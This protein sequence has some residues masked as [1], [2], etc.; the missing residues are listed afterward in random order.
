[1]NTHGFTLV[2]SRR[3]SE[4]NGTANMW[5]HDATGAQLLSVVNDDEN[6]CF[7]AAFRTPPADSTGVAHIMEHSVLCGS[8]KYPVK[9]PFVELLKGS[10]QTFLNAFTFPDKTCYPVASAN[11]QDFYN[12]VDVYID[13]VFHPRI[14]EDIFRQEGWHVEAE[15]PDGPWAYKGVVFNEMK[16]AYSSPDSVLSEKSQQ[17]LFP[18]T[19]YSLDSGGDPERIPD[20]TYEAFRDFHSRYYHPSNARF[21]FWGDDPEEKR[22]AILEDAL[23]GYEA[24]AVDSAIPLQKRFATPRLVEVPYACAEGETRAMFTVNWLLGERGDVMQALLMEMLEHVL[25]GMPGSPLRR[26]LISSGLGEDLTGCGLETDLRQMYYST[27]LKGV[28]PGDVTRAET[29]IFETLG[30]LAENGIAPEAVEAAVNAVEFNYRENNS[31]RFPRGLAAMIQALSTWLYDGDPADAL[32]WETP[33]AEIKA[34]LARGEKV[35]EEAIRENF[36]DNAHRA[37]VVLLPDAGIGARREE[38]E[39]ARVAAV[40]KGCDGKA[41]ER[42]AEET[43]RLQ[44]AQTAPDS[45]EALATIPRLGTGDLPRENAVIPRRESH[46]PE[47]CL[48]HEQPTNGIAYFSLLLPI[49]QVPHRLLPLLP[50]FCRSLTETGT[51]RRDYTALGTAISARTGGIGAASLWGERLDT[52]AP[53]TYLSIGGKSLYDKAGDFFALL[54]E[55]LFEPANDG[56]VLKERL[57]QM[58]LET[59]SRLEESVQVSGS[60]FAGGRLAARYATSAALN[61]ITGGLDYLDSVRGMIERLDREPEAFLADL[62]TLRRAVLSR[63]GAVVECTAESRG[64]TLFTEKARALLDR[65]PEAPAL[66]GDA[67]DAP[68][69]PM[70]L[71]SG[72]AFVTPSRVNFVGKAANLKAAGWQPSGTASVIMRFLRMGYLWERVRV[73]GGAYGASCSLSRATGTLLFTSYRDPNVDGTLD[74]YDGVTDFLRAFTPDKAQ[75]EQAIVGAV[76]DMDLYLLP[77]ARGKRSLLR[78]LCG[79]SDE[80]RQ[81]LREEMLSTTAGDFR[82]FAETLAPL[83]AGDVCVI[84]GQAAEEAAERHGW[85]VRRVL[86]EKGKKA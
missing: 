24:R 4:V 79:E 45:P 13:A 23:K 39:A 16:G 20:L 35:F 55:I 32:A 12:L 62:E 25:E 63:A 83:K 6:K 28:A 70:A 69:P 47:T 50:L 34:R 29:L 11:L 37:T 86:Q 7:T 9:E 8:D 80:E 54:D 2:S 60:A 57:G 41:R 5:R 76:G 61:E 73:R 49:Q 59:R 17:A 64:L 56:A 14:S 53:F 19:L 78:W 22:L 68:F 42:M 3:L 1:M 75:L 84:G 46:L 72:E 77:S 33:L 51:A 40:Q 67:A 21:F 27:G 26:A 85:A 38:A 36:L 74:A 48:T 71:P 43:R 82:D 66:P 44:E 30:D 52:Q 81:K 15:T 10:L 31:G 58:L 18:D 65:L